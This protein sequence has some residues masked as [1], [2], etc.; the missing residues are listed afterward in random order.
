MGICVVTFCSSSYSFQENV[1][2]KFDVKVRRSQILED[3]YR[4]IMSVKRADLLK[5]R[6]VNEKMITEFCLCGCV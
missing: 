4:T 3:S 2:N 1:P 5:T 6:L